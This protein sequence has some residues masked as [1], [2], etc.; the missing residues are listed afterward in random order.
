M[1]PVE[2]KNEKNC[3]IMK[4]KCEK[5]ID[6]STQKWYHINKYR[7]FCTKRRILDVTNGA[8]ASRRGTT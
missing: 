1:V 7:Y 6:K 2:E 4:G 8:F 3:E 5:A